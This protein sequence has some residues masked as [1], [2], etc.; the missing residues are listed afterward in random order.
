MSNEQLTGVNPYYKDEEDRRYTADRLVFFSDA[1]IAIALTLLA[2]EL[3][4]PRGETNAGVWRSFVELLPDEYLDFVISFAVIAVF[5]VAHHQFFRK[6]HAVGAGLRWLNIGWLFLVVLVPFATRVNSEGDGLVL[7]PV[8]YAI[9]IC[10]L[11]V[12]LMLMARH[13]VRAG[14]LHPD[15]PPYAVREM[16]AGAGTAALVFLVSIPVSVVS[17]SWGRTVWVLT[18]LARPLARRLVRRR[19]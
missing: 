4:V 7:G 5:W 2:L 16:V 10:L 12:L 14:L 11:A 1:V 3:P 18:I 6:I 17:P 9:V 8:L 13:A 15:T 19:G